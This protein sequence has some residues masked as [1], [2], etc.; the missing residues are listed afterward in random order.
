M[1][2]DAEA[3]ARQRIDILLDVML[4]SAG[5]DQSALLNG[6]E[7]RHT[8]LLRRLQCGTTPVFALLFHPARSPQ[9]GEPCDKAAAVSIGMEA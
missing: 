3:V 4:C 8:A 2:L 6:I 1:F 9:D 5:H 7:E